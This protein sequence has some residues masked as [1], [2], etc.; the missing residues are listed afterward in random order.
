MRIG[1]LAHRSGATIK[2]IRYYEHR[3]LL[4]APAREPS[5][6]R[7]Y[8]EPHLTQLRFIGNAKRLGLS[9]EEIGDL[10]RACDEAQ[11]GCAHVLTL[12]EAKHAQIDAWIR[13]A[14]A[15]RYD[16]ERTIQDVRRELATQPAP[17]E[18]CP[19]IDR[20]LHQRAESAAGADAALRLPFGRGPA[21]EGERTALRRRRSGRHTDS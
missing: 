9:L 20:G 7:R 21:P 14:H 10:L 17:A 15:F 3:G 1:E 5:G 13:A 16:L 19:I 12:L 2:A 11:P 6:Y 4:S 18:T 8:G